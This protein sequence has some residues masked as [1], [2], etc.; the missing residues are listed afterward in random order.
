MTQFEHAVKKQEEIESLKKEVKRYKKA[1]EIL[2]CY[3]DSIS[4]EEQP[5]VNKKLAKLNL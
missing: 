5:K 2:I 4:D 1:Y 3:F